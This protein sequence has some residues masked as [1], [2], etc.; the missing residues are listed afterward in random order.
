M[1]ICI[2]KQIEKMATLTLKQVQLATGLVGEG[3][4]L[5]EFNINNVLKLKKDKTTIYIY[6]PKKKK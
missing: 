1:Y 4:Q 6:P 2:N 3:Y 5:K